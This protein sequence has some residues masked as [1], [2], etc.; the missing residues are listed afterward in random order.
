MSGG[1]AFH[2]SHLRRL[3]LWHNP[4]RGMQSKGEFVNNIQFTLAVA[5]VACCHSAWSDVLI[6]DVRL[7]DGTG[8]AP[9]ERT[10]VWVRDGMIQAL[11]ADLQPNEST[12][13]IDANGMTVIPGLIDSHVHLFSIPG[14]PFRDESADERRAIQKVHLRAYLA[15]GVTSVLDTGIGLD[16]LQMFRGW[17]AGGEPGPRLYALGPPLS[18]PGGYTDDRPGSA[19]F[20]YNVPDAASAAPMV[21]RLDEHQVDGVKV[22]IEAGFGPMEVWPVHP[23]EVRNAIVAAAQERSLPV[24]IHAM[25]EEEHLIALEMKPHALVHA[26]YFEGEPSDELLALVKLS[27]AYVISTISVADA[28]RVALQP[29]LL[30][31]PHVQLTVPEAQR[32]T[33]R[34]PNAAQGLGREFARVSFP[35]WFPEWLA[36]WASTTFQPAISADPM[37]NAVRRF[38]RAGVSVVMGSDSGNWEVIPWEFHGPT[39]VREV[40]LLHLAGLSPMEALM[41]STSVPARMLGRE[42]EIGTLA[43]G[44]RADLVILPEDPLEDLTVL[45]RPAWVM[46]DGE[47]RT[48]AGWMGVE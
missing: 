13:V 23:P 27:G 10:S 21:A 43:V 42:S 12:Q 25:S 33:A 9:T 45:T 36:V 16:E 7:I 39:S 19:A 22:V 8:A 11:G 41:A 4:R 6:R 31:A 2:C 26:G 28:G 44:W 20:H 5:L 17:L 3:S 46:K 47:I 38:H 48:S 29:K 30:E 32:A 35:T 40:E 15:N 24:Y 18:P 1:S 14:A 37:L 34:D